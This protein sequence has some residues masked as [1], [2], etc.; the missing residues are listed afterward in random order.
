MIGEDPVDL[1]RHGAIAGAQ[2][3]LHMRDP[4]AQLAGDQ[5]TCERRV[6]VAGHD[7]PIGPEV[8]QHR[9][10]PLHDLGGLPRVAA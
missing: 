1:F 10:E 6:D 8:Q 4:D 7:H 5:R 3:G 9:L 2:P